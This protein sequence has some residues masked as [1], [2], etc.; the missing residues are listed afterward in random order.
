MADA[1]FAHFKEHL[2]NKDVD[3]LV[4]NI[5]V[6]LVDHTD[7]TPDPA[8]DEYLHDIDAAARVATSGNMDGKS[9]TH[10]VFDANDV[11]INT[12]T[13][14]GVDSIVIYMD[15]GDEDTSILIAYIDSATGLPYTPSGGNIQIT[16]SSGAYKIFAL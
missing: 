4:D 11:T 6:V 13:G 7:H 3:L 14:D 12:V 1:L 2:L 16:W 10:G 5:K 8:V 15:S 9:T